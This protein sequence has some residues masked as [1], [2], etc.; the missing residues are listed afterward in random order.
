MKQTLQRLI[1][2]QDWA[3][4]LILGILAA[5]PRLYRL[6]LAEFK[7][8]E[9]NHY[10]MA[11]FLTR[12]AWRWVGSTSSVGLP[13][14]PLFVYTLALPMTL[15]RDPRVITGFL[16]ILAALATGAF[17]L[18]L[19]RFM[20][21][22][23]S[24]GA[25]L[26]FA[27]NP[28]AVLYARKLFTADLLPPLCTLFLITGIAFIES[29]RRRV[30]RLAML[31]TFTFALLV[32]TTFSPLIL[33]PTLVLLFLERRRDLKPL[34]WFGAG[35]VFVLPFVPYLV[36]VTPRIPAALANAG[37]APSSTSPSLLLNWTWGMLYGS[38]WPASLSSVV[39]IAALSLL[40]LSLLGLPFLLNEARR[41]ERG[42]WARFFLTWLCLSPLLMLI[43]QV[44]IH[45]HYLVLLYPLLLVLPA[46]GVEIATRK[47]NAL[48]WAALLLLGVTAIW[49]AQTWG[50]VL[51]AAATG[52]QGYGT[53]LGYWW[54]AAEQARELAEQEDAAEVL[55][56]MP[57]DRSWDAKANILDALLSDTPH[58]LVD[59]HTTVVYPPHDTILLIASEVETSVALAF[60]CTQDL[61][62]DLAASPLG[63][64]YHYRLWSPAHAGASSCTQTLLPA[65]AQWASG[66]RLLGYGVTGT[67][68]PGA[69]PHVILHWET[70]QGPLDTDVHWFHHLEDQTGQRWGQFDAVGWPAAR[71]QPGDRVLLHFDLPIAPDAEPGPYILRVGQYTYPGIETIP[72]VDVAGNPADY[73]V[74]LPVPTR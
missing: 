28:Q 67:V 12:G 38:P 13:K 21:K 42:R 54:R 56:L 30:G 32:L 48:G 61:E 5:L 33:L 65:T 62:S 14:P 2:K 6:D 3:F 31:T 15:S 53:P 46:A 4:A 26:L 17:Y 68:Q 8:D 19:R 22:K 10:R 71:W 24:F 20:G 55:L 37:G 35:A 74:A 29:P 23:A 41:K 16:G 69:S 1:P 70:T 39:G 45:A 44:E 49:Q 58:R 40:V 25:A 57:G 9:A 66:V 72:V 7:L 64:T 50:Y 47:A 36:A 60:P 52:S 51:H 11:Y 43:M 27:L 63:G 18:V 73:A 59:G 34:H